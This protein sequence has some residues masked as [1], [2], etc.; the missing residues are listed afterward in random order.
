VVTS[1][2]SL[3]VKKYRVLLGL[4]FALS[5][6]SRQI[7]G[8]S[9]AQ[10]EIFNQT[11]LQTHEHSTAEK[12]IHVNPTNTNQLITE[13]NKASTLVEKA[14]KEVIYKKYK[15]QDFHTNIENEGSYKLIEAPKLKG[16][17]S[18]H[19]SHKPI[20]VNSLSP[21]Y[22]SDLGTNSLT[23][24]SNGGIFNRGLKKSNCYRGIS[25]FS[26]WAS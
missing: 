4:F 2:Y 18:F 21:P 22:V 23:K 3:S 12:S 24:Y 9:G 15:T 8:A 17:F 10:V 19:A 5:I 13:N 26:C 7:T 11:F 25:L 6:L 20:F 14:S 16:Y 1:R